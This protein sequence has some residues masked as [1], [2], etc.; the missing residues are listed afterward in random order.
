MSDIVLNIFEDL[1]TSQEMVGS[2]LIYRE[3]DGQLVVT[4]LD[5]DGND[6]SHYVVG[7]TLEK[8]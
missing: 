3:E 1:L 8:I 7:V 2:E 5:A 4:T 6:I